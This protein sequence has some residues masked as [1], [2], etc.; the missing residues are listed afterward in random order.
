M[1]EAVELLGARGI[2]VGIQPPVAQAIVSIGVD[3]SRIATLRSLRDA[4]VLCMNA[5]LTGRPAR[6]RS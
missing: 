2:V 5:E 1:V 4:L 6:R 3:L